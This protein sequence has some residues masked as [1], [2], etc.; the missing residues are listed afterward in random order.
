M[1]MLKVRDIGA[2][3]EGLEKRQ[4]EIV[5]LLN[6]LKLIKNWV[7]YAMQETYCCR[8]ELAGISSGMARRDSLILGGN[9]IQQLQGFRLN[10]PDNGPYNQDNQNTC[11]QER[12]IWPFKKRFPDPGRR[13]IFE[14][15]SNISCHGGGTMDTNPR[16]D[17]QL[18]NILTE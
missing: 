8:S 12:F 10:N 4:E 18:S 16:G 9:G 6:S 1:R 3:M 5:K 17:I 7:F 14:C 15:I 2:R 11:F 13:G